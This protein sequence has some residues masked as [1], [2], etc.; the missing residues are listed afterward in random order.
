MGPVPGTHRVLTWARFGA[1]IRILMANVQQHPEEPSSSL[2]FES[3][4][5]QTADRTIE[6]PHR[7]PEPPLRLDE[8]PHAIELQD[9]DSIRRAH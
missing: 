9:S 4:P 3:T 8:G 6:E 5:W 1:Q 7:V 2:A